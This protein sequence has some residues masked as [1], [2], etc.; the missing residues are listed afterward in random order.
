MATSKDPEAQE[1]SHLVRSVIAN[2]GIAFLEPD[3]K[4]FRC[5]L[6]LAIQD[7]IGKLTAAQ[8]VRLYEAACDVKFATDDVKAFR[9]NLQAVVAKQHDLIR[10]RA[11]RRAA[12]TPGK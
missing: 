10:Y 4:K 1:L 9:V 11:T 5:S 8:I 2:L 3:E 6:L 7:C 12:T